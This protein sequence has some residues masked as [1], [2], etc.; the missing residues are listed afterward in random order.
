[1][2]YKEA[3]QVALDYFGGDKLAANVYLSKYAL[4]TP[5]GD[6]LEPSPSL[7]HRRLAKEFARIEAK[8]PNP[9][10]EDEIFGYLD[11]FSK[12]IPQRLTNGSELVIHINSKVLAIVLLF[13]QVTVMEPFARQMKKWLKSSK[14]EE[15]LA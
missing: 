2:D 8:Y 14:E 11:K 3:F 12:I 5:D 15:E 13:P 9:L 10:N 4:K 6:I 1:M 7:M